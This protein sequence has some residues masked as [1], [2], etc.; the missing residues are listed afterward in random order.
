MS[1]YSF[2]NEQLEIFTNRES[3]NE[4]TFIQAYAG[5]GKTTTIEHYAK[6]CI[7]KKVLYLTFNNSLT[8]EKNSENIEYYT[9]HGF[10][11]KQLGI[12]SSDIKN[13]SLKDIQTMYNIEYYY[14]NSILN[15]YNYFLAST[16]LLPKLKHVYNSDNDGLQN[17]KEVL[18]YMKD[19]WNKMENKQCKMCHDYY[20]K[21]FMI[22][23]QKL[24]Y[25]IILIDECQ[26][27]TPCVM[28]I[29]YRTKCKKV[30]VGDIYQQIYGFRNVL[31]PFKLEYID[32][33]N[34]NLSQ[35]FRFGSNVAILCNKFLNT[36]YKLKTPI[37]MK[38][39]D[40]LSTHIYHHTY[41]KPKDYAYITRTNK[42]I[43]TYAYYLAKNNKK[44]SILG[45]SYDF[46]KEIKIFDSLK[47][48]DFSVFSTNLQIESL[49]DAKE[50]YKNIQNYKWVLRIELV[51]EYE[52]NI[53]TF[54]KN[55][56]NECAKIKLLTSHQSKGLEF[57]N[58]VLA[59][60]YKP[61][62][63]NRTLT[64]NNYYK[65]DEYNLI[66]VAI[67]RAKEKL[68]LNKNFIKYLMLVNDYNLHY[69]ED[70]CSIKDCK[71]LVP[72]N[73][74]GLYTYNKYIHNS[75]NTPDYIYPCYKIEYN[76]CSDCAELYRNRIINDFKT[77][78]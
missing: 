68:Y 75:N 43:L 31:N 36:F 45:K 37:A 47:S 78:W 7:G 69:K 12:D 5:S 76:C 58:V 62:V 2:T 9:I 71:Q 53:W 72:C 23:N 29:L 27:L 30:F 39:N 21:K 4:Y 54:I 33:V 50:I 44:F 13:L 66:Y 73:Y 18:Y 60:D 59:N 20:L 41:T 14:A 1:Q 15:G 77:Y 17:H 63:H 16:S 46:D 38:G 51:D 24:E 22:K 64:F 19:L 52:E 55:Y 34:Y 65:N 57:E 26:D 40:K 61:L 25:D 11:Y 56:H 48:K 6:M 74:C 35:S 32:R 8:N 42:G 28:K 3:S 49:N 67:T 70:N 10:A